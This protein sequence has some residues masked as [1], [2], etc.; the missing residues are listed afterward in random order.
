MADTRLEDDRLTERISDAYCAVD[1]EWRLT[2]WNDRMAEWTGTSADA[3]AGESLWDVCPA[4]RGSEIESHCRDALDTQA[5]RSFETTLPAPIDRQVE[6]TCYADE[7]GLSLISRDISERQLTQAQYEL[8]E[9]LF[10]NTQDALFLI[11][12]DEPTDEFRVERINP[13]YEYNTGLRNAEISG[14]RLRDLFG[15]SQGSEFLD[16]YR[17]CVARREPIE[18]EEVV[19][20]PEEKSCWETRI[21]PVIVDGTTEKIVGATRNITDRKTRERQYD[22]IFNQ[23]YQ[24]T[25][26]LSVDGTL[27]EA[28]DSV[29]R[30]G[31]FERDEVIGKPVWETEWWQGSVATQEKLQSAIDSAADGAFVRY[32]AEVQGAKGTVII[33]FSL[34]PITDEQN[35]VTHLVAEG[36]D[37]TDHKRRARELARSREFLNQI[38]KTAAVGGWEFEFETERSQWTDEL[39]RILGVDP[40]VEPAVEEALRFYHPQDRPTVEAAFE[41]LQATGEPYDLEIQVMTND[42]EVLWVRTLG[43]PWYDD[44]GQLVGA[45]GAF[46]DI[47]DRKERER[48]LQRTNARLEEFTSVVSHDLRNPLTVAQASLELG[49]ES[50]DPADFDR[51]EAAH[52]RMDALITDLL[53]L[54]REGRQVEATRPVVLK[55]VIEAARETIPSD[56]ATIDV[57]LDDYCLESDESRLRQLVENLLSNAVRHGGEDVTVQVGL[58]PDNAGFYFADDGP[59]IPPS[60]RADV[61][62]QGY[63]TARDGSGFGLAIVRAVAEAHDWTVEATD[64]AAGGA[65]FEVTVTRSTQSRPVRSATDR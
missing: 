18:Y 25:G 63:S 64:G 12:V 44:S 38:Q 6:M 47:T 48:E 61:F 54:A 50:A 24:F 46:Q 7:S 23:T 59:G 19:S 60:M 5:S 57:E 31:G 3:V 55:E 40:D 21:A 56:Q 34:R 29:L 22:A 26:L 37:I 45:R 49:R 39:Y 27:L 4:F 32:D 58:L 8:A 36:R 9:T 13:A 51:V 43:T 10:E 30:F 16:N 2:Y 11:D 28:N 62:T 52:E 14:R 20:I 33:D 15:D 17:E 65:R 1:T 53:T 35:E 42:D 41:R